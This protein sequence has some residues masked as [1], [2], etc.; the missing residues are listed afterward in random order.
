MD[1]PS[2]KFYCH[3]E[4]GGHRFR[5]VSPELNMFGSYPALVYESNHYGNPGPAVT[6]PVLTVEQC[7][8]MISC[9]EHI[10]KTHLEQDNPEKY[11][12]EFEK[13]EVDLE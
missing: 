7:D 9:L 12:Y 3:I 13:P 8:A 4:N 11:S 2:M 6:I 10:K 1:K 5:A